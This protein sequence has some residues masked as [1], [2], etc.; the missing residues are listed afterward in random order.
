LFTGKFVGADEFGNKYYSNSKGRRWVI[1]KDKIESSKIPPEWHLWIHFLVKNK[2]SENL[3][4][5]QW[6]KKYEENL[7]GTLKAYRPEGSLK[8]DSQ[9]NTKKYET[10]KI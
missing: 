8:S 5:F 3:S 7:T 1:Y 9:K 6:Q 4:K 10:W 2:P